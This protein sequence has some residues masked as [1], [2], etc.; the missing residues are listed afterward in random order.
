MG[1]SMTLNATLKMGA[2]P[3]WDLAITVTLKLMLTPTLNVNGMAR[4]AMKIL[5]THV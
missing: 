1:V 2:A 5:C 3:I 4:N